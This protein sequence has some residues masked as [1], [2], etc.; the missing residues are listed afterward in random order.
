MARGKPLNDSERAQRR[1]AHWDKIVNGGPKYSDGVRG[2]REKWAAAAAL[3]LA[4]KDNRGDLEKLGLSDLPSTLDEL[5][6]AWKKAMVL[7]HPDRGGSNEEAMQV[8]EAYDRIKTHFNVPVSKQAKDLS[9]YIEPAKAQHIEHEDYED[10][11][12]D[13]NYMNGNHVA[14]KKLDGSRYILYLDETPKL[15][16]RRISDVT[17]QY[18]DKTLN[19][20][21]LTRVS[22]PE[23][24]WG[25]VLD[26]EMVHP[27]SEKS[28]STTSI[29]GCSPDEAVDRQKKEGWL[30]YCVYDLPKDRNEDIRNKPLSERKKRLE[31]LVS[32]LKKHIPVAILPDAP[33]TKAKALYEKIVAAGGEGVM[34]KDLRSPYGKG[35]YK[36]K[37]VMTWDVVIMGYQA[38]K[39]TSKKVDGKVSVTAL[40]K[41]G[42]IGAVIFGAYKNGKLKELGTVSGMTETVRR[43]LSTNGD[44]Y[45]GSVIE[46]RFQERTKSGALRH[47][48]FVRFRNDK[49]A[50]QCIDLV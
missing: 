31:A 22:I 15:L 38:P 5:K 12:T 8:N 36:V 37:K 27:K 48:R 34:V 9:E 35:W 29:M 40:H 45:I 49:A 46:I 1:K 10:L 47:A 43:E 19:C 39:K 13:Q 24:F 3:I 41:K 4:S 32:K 20:P 42:L 50:S 30:Q 23:E 33:M 25:T 11:W 44:K 26:G 28:D 21:H 14:E 16:S 7:A 18:V 17:G 6:K 2:S